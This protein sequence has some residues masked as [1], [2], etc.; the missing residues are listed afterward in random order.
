MLQRSDGY[1]AGEIKIDDVLKKVIFWTFVL[2][3][4]LFE[5]LVKLTH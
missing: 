3:N 2:K 4:R 1:I 5:K